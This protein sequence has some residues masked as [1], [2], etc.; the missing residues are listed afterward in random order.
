MTQSQTLEPKS[1]PLLIIAEISE[2]WNSLAQGFGTYWMHIGQGSLCCKVH[3]CSVWAIKPNQ[4]K[5]TLLGTIGKLVWLS[6]AAW[7]NDYSPWN[8]VQV[9]LRDCV[10]YWRKKTCL[11][12]GEPQ[13]GC[14]L[15]AS[16]SIISA[17]RTQKHNR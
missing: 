12:V 14:W 10:S 6:S 1:Q 17:N 3:S 13:Y 2:A 15:A 16:W 8:Y 9:S 11:Y 4:L 7:W 5:I